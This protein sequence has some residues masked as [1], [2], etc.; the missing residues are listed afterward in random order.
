MAPTDTPTQVSVVISTFNRLDLLQELLDALARQTLPASR[1]E[2]IVVDDGSKVPVAPA[3][4]QR[5]DPYRLSLVSQANA[6]AAA[7]R[8]AGIERA[9]G[10]VIVI[11][12]DDMLVRPD[13]LEQHLAAHA[14][15][16]SLV[17]GHIANEEA[18]ASQPLFDRFHAEHLEDFVERFSTHPT[19]VKGA[20]MYTGNVS[21]RR[22]D[23]LAVGGFDPTLKRSEDRELGLRL[24]KAGAK[25]YFA[26]DAV[27]MNRSDHTDL[28]QWRRRNFL[29]GVFDSRIHKKHPDLLEADP[30]HF[31]FQVNPVSRGLLLLS[32]AAPRLGGLLA[33]TAYGVADA[34]D[35]GRGLHPVLG[36]AAIAGATLSYGLDYFRGVREEAGSLGRA[37]R[38]FVSHTRAHLGRPR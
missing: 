18:R 26:R 14:A 35:H 7:A 29:Y 9:V 4:G 25:P 22:D 1:F 2:V 33:R 8:H 6:G 34:L 19:E 20:M 23:Y 32:A 24:E 27:A 5:T 13:F 37:T 38:D 30:W 36:R 16:H 3:L 31:I 17:L 28:E 10:E 11:T 12:D 15:G 21:F